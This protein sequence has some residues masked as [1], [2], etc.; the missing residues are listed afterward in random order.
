[1]ASAISNEK[2]NQIITAAEGL[3]QSTGVAPSNEMVREKLGGGSMSYI[4]PVM[5]EWRESL[6][7]KKVQA[8]T[9]PESVSQAMSL[10]LVG[11]WEAAIAE[12]S[13]ELTH[14]KTNSTQEIARL[15]EE[16]DSALSEIEKM[17]ADKEL[18][19]VERL[20]A[21]KQL[22]S[23]KAQLATLD[24]QLDKAAHEADKCNLLLGASK[25]KISALELELKEQ[26]SLYASLQKE[27]I[28]IASNAGA[29]K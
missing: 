16:R 3:F 7:S 18:S 25:E 13:K 15:T 26:K 1:M 22:E 29:K 20:G 4:Q 21:I 2:R 28:K 17:E 27:L 10:S 5:R 24:K 19:D 23:A 14:Y 9:M 11:M 12:A 6:E 8:I